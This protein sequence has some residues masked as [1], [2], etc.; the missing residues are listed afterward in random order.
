MFEQKQIWRQVLAIVLVALLL[1][2]MVG[3]IG[4]HHANYSATTCPICHVS[5]QAIEPPVADARAMVLVPMG[6]G[7]EPQRYHFIPS[8]AAR[9]IAARAPPA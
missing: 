1:G 6:P 9:H 5:H 4:H 7:P 8:P 2:T 3:E